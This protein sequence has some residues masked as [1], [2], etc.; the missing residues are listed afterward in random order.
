MTCRHGYPKPTMC[1]DCMDDDPAVRLPLAD[2]WVR[3]DRHGRCAANPDHTVHAGDLIGE[4]G[5]TGWVCE[6]CAR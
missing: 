1:R 5:W 4:L 2:R 3:A 6:R